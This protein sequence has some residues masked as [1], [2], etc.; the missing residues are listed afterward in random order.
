MPNS[1]ID[2]IALERTRQQTQEGWT[3]EHDDA[4]DAGTLAAAAT[5]YALH[6]ADVLNPNS[7]GDGGY[8]TTP[9]DAVALPPM[10]PWDVDWWNPSGSGTN[11]AGA[12]RDLV[13][14]AALIVAEI[15]RMDRAAVSE[16]ASP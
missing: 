5:A 16:I 6:A 15:E 9:D 2:E 8:K 12:R 1:I 10:W 13:K 11:Q 14:A 7:Q 3:T 4:H